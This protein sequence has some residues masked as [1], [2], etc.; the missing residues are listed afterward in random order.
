MKTRDREMNEKGEPEDSSTHD[1]QGTDYFSKPEFYDQGL[2][3]KDELWVQKQR[4]GRASDAVLCC[5]ACFTTLCLDC[6]RHEKYVTQYRAIF[7]MNCR[8]MEEVPQLGSKRKRNKRGSHIE[9]GPSAA[10]AFKRVCC[11]VCSTEVGVIDEDEVYHFLNVL[12]SEA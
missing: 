12:P 2:D 3:D 10:V 5:P 9:V 6:Q 4:G 1:S 11:S 7:V 8:I